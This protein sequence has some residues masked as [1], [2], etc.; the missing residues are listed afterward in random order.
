VSSTDTERRI[1]QTQDIFPERL[2][3]RQEV[4]DLFGYPT[5]R[6]LEVAALRGDGPPMHK[7][8]RSVRYRVSDLR[9]WIDA[10][11]VNST[12]D[13]GR[14][15][16]TGWWCRPRW[17]QRLPDKKRLAVVSKSHLKLCARHLTVTVSYHLPQIFRKG[18][19]LHRSQHGEVSVTAVD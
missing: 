10:H 13:Q 14:K 2:L 11:R 12:S 16:S 9:A 4:E 8:G 17:R 6:F 5:K 18:N 1:M 19:G 3:N 15:P 7:I